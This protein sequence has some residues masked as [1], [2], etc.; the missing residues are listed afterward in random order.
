MVWRSQL[1]EHQFQVAPGHPA[2]AGIQALPQARQA[3]G[4]QTQDRPGQAGENAGEPEDQSGLG[5]S[6]HRTSLAAAAT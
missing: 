4:Q 2:F 3:V 6:I 5:R 1:R